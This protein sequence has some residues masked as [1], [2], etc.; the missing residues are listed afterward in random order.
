MS[1]PSN[2]HSHLQLVDEAAARPG[3]PNA[4]L[5][6]VLFCVVEAMFFAGLISA[7]TIVRS[8]AIEWPPPGQPRLPV[9]RTM[10]NTA[11]LLLSAPALFWAGRVFRRSRRAALRPMGVAM[12]L[13]AFFVAFQG[14]EWLN[15]LREGLTLTSSQHGSFF[16]LIVG[17]HAA[18]AVAAIGALVWAF[19]RLLDLRLGSGAFGA[20]AVFWY[21]VVAVW[22]VLYWRVYL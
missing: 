19:G 18:H 11:A 2:T 20:T 21:F 5:G 1:A 7:H 15:L 6:M 10:I 16:Y 9:E 17:M 3:V 13:G 8:N 22:P 12:A 4:V 14:W